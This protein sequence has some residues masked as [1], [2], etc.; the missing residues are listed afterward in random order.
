MSIGAILVFPCLFA[1]GMMLVDSLNATMMI[2][3]YTWGSDQQASRL[4]YNVVITLM[5]SLV[6]IF[7][8]S[9]QTIGML[10]EHFSPTGQLGMRIAGIQD[11]I[12]NLG[13][14]MLGIAVTCWGIAAL[15]DRLRSKSIRPAAST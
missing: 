10:A 2:G 4:R 12:S 15:A 6:A 7:I 9:V 11:H 5:S 14:Y 3:A 1:A 8:G 13:Y